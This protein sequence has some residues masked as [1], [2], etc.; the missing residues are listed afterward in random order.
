MANEKNLKPIKLTHEEAVKNGKKGGVASAKSRKR[1]KGFQRALN[2]MLNH[3][4]MEKDGTELTGYEKIALSL[5][6]TATNV[7]NKQSVNAI[8]L[9][10][11][12]TGEARTDEKKK[13]E[14]LMN[15]LKEAEIQLIETRTKVLKDNLWE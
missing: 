7:E 4:F 5:F 1:K 10:F 12:L 13:H 14:Q 6:E 11:E 3:T 8:R 9:I 2:E 15:Q